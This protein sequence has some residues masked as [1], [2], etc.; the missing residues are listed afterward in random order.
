MEINNTQDI[1]DSRDIIARIEELEASEELEEL[2]EDE[3]EELEILQAL[4]DEGRGWPDWEHGT[5]LINDTYFTEY[6][7]DLAEDLGLVNDYTM[8]PATCINWEYAAEQLQNDYALID[9]DGTEY[10]V[11]A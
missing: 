6:A 2:E 4:D 11:R 3:K 8:W 5:T 7:Q 10:W 9:F 1:I